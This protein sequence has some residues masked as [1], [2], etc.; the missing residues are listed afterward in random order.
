MMISNPVSI[1]EWWEV[2]NPS[3]QGMG[4]KNEGKY[5]GGGG[6][7]PVITAFVQKAVEGNLPCFCY[8]RHMFCISSVAERAKARIGKIR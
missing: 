8:A 2:L 5:R 6:G 4:D 7:A 1:D 3:V